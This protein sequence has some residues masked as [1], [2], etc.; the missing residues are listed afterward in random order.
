MCSDTY[1]NEKSR[2]ARADQ[3]TSAATSVETNDASSAFCAESARRR[4]RFHAAYEPATS[5]YA[6]R[7]RLRRSAARPSPA[8]LRRA[9]RRLVLRGALRRERIRV[10]DEGPVGERARDDD[11]AP[12]LVGVGNAAVVDDRRAGRRMTGDVAQH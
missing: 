6:T 1:T 3:S 8:T 5:A 2:R 12:H 11:L 10:R 4:R 9:L 7:P